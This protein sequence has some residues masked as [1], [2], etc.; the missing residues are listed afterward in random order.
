MWIALVGASVVAHFAFIA[1][2]ALGGIVA[3]RW[4]RT[5]PCHVFAVGW[6]VLSVAQHLDC[7]L[8]SLERWSRARAGMAE[9]PPDGFIA[10]YITGVLYPTAWSDPV[11]VAVFVIV[12]V[13]WVAIFTSH[14]RRRTVAAHE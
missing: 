12:A 2:L 9:L 10:H 6:A 14:V 8:T 13:S 7:P 11:Q 1:Y 4:R 5:M 3:L